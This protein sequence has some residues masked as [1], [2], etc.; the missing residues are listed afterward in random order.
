MS[1]STDTSTVA[2]R[3]AEAPA[4]KPHGTG[5]DLAIQGSRDGLWDWDLTSD[6]V[7]YSERWKELLGIEHETIS[8]SPDEWLDRIVSSD[9]TQFHVDLTLHIEGSIQQLDRQLRMQHG[10]GSTRWMLCR[11]TALRDE[12]GRAVRLAGSL[13]D[14]TELKQAQEELRRIAQHDRLTGLPNRETF[15]ERLCRSVARAERDSKYHF[16]VL[17]FDFDRFKVINDSLG[18][19]VGDALLVSIAERFA[20]HLR[21]A[22]T[23]A[24]FGGD[25]FVVLLD[26]I[27]GVD[28]AERISQHLL[29]VFAEPHELNGQ[30]V[31]STASIGLVS[32]EH[33]YDAAEDMIRDADAAMY[34]AKAQGKGRYHLF[35]AAMHEQIVQRLSLEQEMRQCSFEDEF[36]LLY[37]PIV[38]LERG[39]T[40]GLEALVRWQHPE[41]GRIA[42]D[43]FIDIAEETGLII[44]LGEWILRT[45]C[46]QLKQWHDA[47]GHDTPLIMNV[48]V[49]KRQLMHPG[50]CDLLLDVIDETGVRAG[51]LNLEI[52]ETT[53]MDARHD[54]V[55][56]M[57]R[58]RQIGVQ[59]AL[60]DFGTGESSLSCLHRFP[61]DMLKIDRTFIDNIDQHRE[62]SA[63]MH[64]IVT[65]A[66][67]L[68][69]DVVAEGIENREQLAQL[70]AM[71]CAY[72]QGYLFTRPLS[73]DAVPGFIADGP[74]AT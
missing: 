57:R 1:T 55:D 48:N 30:R 9:L 2:P 34:Q 53:V 6:T 3:P 29:E 41:R 44:P 58:V 22:D 15:T 13:A 56:V 43:T 4:A 66:D 19:S 59:L 67:N 40:T 70:Q 60:D 65:L 42:P 21:P 17:F 61:L 39:H 74:V 7:H 36:E 54:V 16:A 72:A 68:K 49:S 35:D 31:A 52:T 5:F 25:E 62:F 18:H 20:E 11:A 24:R 26:G 37:H 8:D 14:I 28:E 63:V 10:D 50:F 51:E 32:S 38:S 47:L 12:S 46:H 23:V 33:R 73:A 45:A 64:A 71:E 69:L 27:A